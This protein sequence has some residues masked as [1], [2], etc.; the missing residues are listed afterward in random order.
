MR[1]GRGAGAFTSR[2][3]VAGRC[4]LQLAYRFDE[5]PDRHLTHKRHRKKENPLPFYKTITQKS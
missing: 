4:T 1:R 3:L 2:I 5:N